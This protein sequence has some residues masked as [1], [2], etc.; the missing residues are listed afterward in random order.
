M[1]FILILL[2]FSS[3]VLSKVY[4]ESNYPLRSNNLNRV[5]NE[6]NIFL[7]LW[8]LQ[9]LKDVKDIKMSTVGPDTVIYV[10]R[11]PIVK[12]VNVQ[13]NW[14]VDDEEVK[15]IILVREGEPLVDFDEEVA[16]ETLRVYYARKGF[17]NARVSIKVD[18]NEEGFARVNVRV[19][20]GDVFFLGGALF[21][22]AKSFGAERLM[23]E[24]GLRVGDVFN[25]EEARRGVEKIYSLYREEGF[26]ESSVYFGGVEKRK[27]ASP[28]FRVLFPG[29]E[30]ASRSVLGMFVPFFRGVSNLLSHP[31]GVAKALFGKGSI[32]LPRYT[33]IE[34]ARYR[35]AFEGNLSFGPERLLRLIDLDTPGVDILFL[36]RSRRSIEDFYRSKG[37]FDVQ[38]SYTFE[39]GTIT[40]LID[41]GKRYSLKVLGFRGIDLPESY[42]RELIEERVREFL[43]RVRAQG[44]L[45]ARVKL[46][47]EVN[48]LRKVVYLVVDYLPGKKVWI[49]DIV[50][51]GKDREFKEL[52]GKYRAVLPTAFREELIEELNKDI[53][54]ELD[55]RGYL[56]GDFSV[57]IDVKEDKENLFLTYLYSVV[58]GHRYRYGELLIYGNEKTRPR[59]IY[60]TVVKEKFYSSQAEEESLWNLIQSENYTGVRI[61][62][63]VDR[64]SK[65]VHRLVEVREDKR[66]VIELA[67]GYNTEEKFKAEGGIKLK[68]LFG[69]GIIMNLRG[70]KSQKYETYEVGLSDK[71]LFSRKYFAD[72]SV[73]RRLEFHNSY[74]LESEG[75]FLSFGY[76]M[77]RWFS[78]SLFFSDTD[79]RVSGAG[80][81]EFRLKK[82]GLFLLRE[83]RDDPV[84]PRNMTHS[85]FR[86]M[87]AEG[88]GEYYKVEVNNFV[89]RELVRGLSVNAKLAGGW[90]G[91]E[92]PVFDRFF[93]GGLK[94]M[95]GYDFESIGSPNGGRTYVFGRVELLFVVR[96]PLWV[97]LYTDAGGV[98][99]SFSESFK[100]TKHDVGT[101]LGISTP[102]GF[103]RLDLAKPLSKL[104]MPTSKFKVYLSIGFVY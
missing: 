92:A 26:L 28:F 30:G 89:L 66:G 7:V 8:V 50:F 29:I 41:E 21:E 51:V 22:G 101:A 37:F 59:E 78:T 97:G 15:N 68:N 10:E 84:N 52:F 85:S 34:G 69:V 62:H 47:E 23:Y 77:S 79:N 70:S 18:V 82:Y 24:A 55:R 86:L 72:I 60:Y 12:E 11:Y 61:E 65:R 5:L 91:K 19:V 27:M 16:S 80:A 73:F 90:S 87:K 94:D 54:R 57:V 13:G 3:V 9:K 4:L 95:K 64:E 38:V 49:R 17:L 31:V 2:L 74:D 98:G 40:F 44:Y 36:E 104:D 100:G 102:A 93:L 14:F 83:V 63:F 43:D 96:D 67:A 103:I 88:D 81:G 53:R 1:R 33:V 35:I 32:A 39:G 75:Y 42:D 71:F 99:D 6:E 46:L 48:R 58:K 76:R 25:E 45:T 56:D 20:E